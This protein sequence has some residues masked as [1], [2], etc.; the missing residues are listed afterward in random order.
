MPLKDTGLT[1]EYD[2]Y[3]LRLTQFEDLYDTLLYSKLIKRALELGERRT[4]LMDMG[5]GSSIPSLLAA[6]KSEIKP[7]QVIAVDIDEEAEVTGKYNAKI[8]GL[9]HI[10]S[11]VHMT[12]ED[13]LDRALN[14]HVPLTI[15]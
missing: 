9:E 5:A 15:V 3:P 6:K 8:L 7:L 14:S 12:M 2:Q 10:Y 4:I 13:A 1:H 11:F